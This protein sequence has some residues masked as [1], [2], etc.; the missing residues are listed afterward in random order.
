MRVSA[1]AQRKR[2]CVCEQLTVGLMRY[3]WRRGNKRSLLRTD[4]MRYTYTFEDDT[5]D[6]IT[7]N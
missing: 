6:S 4:E 5:P 2:V 7:V 1:N 3:I